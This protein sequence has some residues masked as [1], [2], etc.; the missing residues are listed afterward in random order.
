MKISIIVSTYSGDRYNDLINLL[1]SIKLQTHSDADYDIEPIIIVDENKDLFDKLNNDEKFSKMIFVFNPKNKG[2]SYSRNIG[3][4]RASGEIFAF[5]DDDAL[6]CHNWAKALVETFDN[7][8]V[9]AVAGHIIPIWEHK[10]MSWFPKELFW[11]ISCSYTMTPNFKCEVDRGFGTNMAFKK[12]VFEKVGMFDTKLGINGKNWIGGEDT[13]MFLK[14]KDIG[15]KVMFNPDAKVLHK[16]YRS[17][18]NMLKIINRAFSGGNSVAIMKNVRRYNLSNSVE[19]KYIKTLIFEFYPR[20]FKKLT[21][22][23]MESIKQIVTVTL[24]ITAESIGYMYGK[25]FY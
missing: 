4:M 24:V 12:D 1:E 15:K 25:Y 23:T 19:N 5:I 11:M 14:V 3:I 6:A 21:T 2:L 10:S 7:K 9:G 13:V 8:D 20:T 17:R 22:N 18:I 16:V